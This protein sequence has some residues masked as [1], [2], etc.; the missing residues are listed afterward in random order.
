VGAIG[1]K[2][3]EALSGLWDRIGS[4][5]PGN[6]EPVRARRFDQLCLKAYGIP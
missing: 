6:V 1:Q 2:L 4:R 3:G 5:N